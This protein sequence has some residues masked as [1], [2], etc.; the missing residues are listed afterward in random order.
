MHRSTVSTFQHIAIVLTLAML[1][2]DRAAAQSSQVHARITDA[3]NVN[4]LVTL[5]GNTH[6]LARLE[7]DR[8]PA[9]S[10]LAL[11]RMLLVLTRS[12]EQESALK[13]LLDQQQDKSSPNYHRWLTPQQFGQQFGAADSDIAQVTAWLESYGFHDVHVANG[14]VAIEFSGTASRLESAFHTSIHKFVFN[15]EEHWANASDPQIPAALAP[16]VA[17]VFTLHNFLKAPQ[18]QLAD[19]KFTATVGADG[20]PQFSSGSGLHALVPADY[21]KI[22]NFGA[23][24]P[25]TF[26]KIA[27]VARSNINTEDVLNF[28]FYTFDQAFSPQ[29]ILNGPDPGDLGG[30]EEAEAVLDSTWS[31][32]AAP[33]AGVFLVVSQTTAMTDGVDLSE[34]YI[35]E[36]NLTDVM[37]ESFGN[38]EGNLTSAE[39]AGIS[40]LAQQAAT[41][42][43]AYVVSA[44]DSGSAGCDNPHTETVATHPPS[45]NVLASTPYTVAVGGTMFNE[46]A[47]P[48]KYWNSTNNPETLE[49]VISYI[50][51]D[52]WNESC[53]H[54]AAG[55]SNPNIFAG[56]GGPSNFFSK[57]SWQA[58]VSGI[59]ADNHR[60]LPDVS[61]TAA[62]HDPYLICLRASCV[63]N[64]QGQIFFV[65]ASGTSA[66]APAFAGILALVNQQ[67]F[68]R[69]GQPNYVLYRLAAAEAFA[70]CNASNP[71][72]PPGSTC[73]FNDVTVGNN[74]VPGE[75]G[76]GT[77]TAPYQT[78]V[79]YDMATGLGS[80]NVSNLV[81]QWNSITFNSTTTTFSISP[82][83]TVVHGTPL[84]VSGTVTSGGGN[85]QPAGVVWVTEGFSTTSPGPYT[86]DN[87]LATFPLSSQGTY[88]GTTNALPGG[89][90]NVSA[91]YA[92]D[93]TFG[94]SDAPNS[95]SVNISAEPTTVTFTAMIKNPSGVLVPFT[96]APFGTPVYFQA[97]VN[98]QSGVGNPTGNVNF[99]NNQA[100]EIW[101]AA[102]GAGGVAVALPDAQIP[103]GNYSVTPYYVGDNSFQPSSGSSPITFAITGIGTSTA[104]GSQLN[105]QGL[106]LNATV[107]ATSA[108]SA[109]TGFITFSNGNTVLAI[110]GLTGGNPSGGIITSTASFNGTQLT[111]GQYN[112]TASYAG[113]AD[114]GSSASTSVQM[115]LTSDFTIANQGIPSLT[116]T[117]GNPAN[118]I[119]DIVVRP[120]FGYSGMVTVSCTTNAPKTTCTPTPASLPVS[121]GNVNIGSI[122]VTTT[123]NAEVVVREPAGRS[124]FDAR[125]ASIV[126]TIAL[127]LLFLA[128]FAGARR[129]RFAMIAAVLIV[130]TVCVAG[131]GCGGG[132]SAATQPP[133]PPPPPPQGTPPNT[134]TVTITG[135]ANGTSHTT[136][137]TLVV[138]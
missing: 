45:V 101:G 135:T 32:A 87:A 12:P 129:R 30:N 134:Y 14:R 38:C 33:S 78:G 73:V 90:Y 27:I 121:N 133:P 123:S 46:G 9:P 60:D 125:P 82:T 80:I 88:G 72:T 81:S 105:S 115:T 70:Q 106:L 25:D 74:S 109:P 44:G 13:S 17:G 83:T 55:C 52:P 112:F 19:E 59:P 92:G 119:N 96:S 2:G 37:T 103:A 84:N 126:C 110:S 31:A 132:G 117:A 85:G 128:R 138:Q 75:T 11:N 56:G 94:G 1:G 21:W 28:H 26:A 57:P 23:S 65:G 67:T 122:L 97:K 39:A 131:V 107:T 22:Y 93:G 6:P 98:G 79:G 113:D 124:P 99:Y 61:L 118:Y 63:P 95:F 47:N 34:M 40:S 29:V 114:Y 69:L 127:L 18:I 104:L 136:N 91:H 48:A 49:S 89:F 8:G 86:G 7:F 50:P 137:L 102:L 53:A 35:I 62:G 41:Q 43:I 16:V 108:G 66:S 100:L 42:G 77:A 130:M 64:A 5:K 15:E 68:V 24:P 116:V 10:D 120:L 54:G 58:G 51:E 36:N 111:P 71:T 3:I 4:N 20:H 76:Y